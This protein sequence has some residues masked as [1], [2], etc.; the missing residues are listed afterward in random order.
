MA[1]VMSF[2][3]AA[4][5]PATGRDEQAIEALVSAG[6]VADEG[7]AVDFDDV[8]HAALQSGRV[9]IKHLVRVVRRDLRREAHVQAPP[10]LPGLVPWLGFAGPHVRV[11]EHERRGEVVPARVAQEVAEVQRVPGAVTQHALERRARPSERLDRFAAEGLHDD[12]VGGAPQPVAASG[13]DGQVGKFP[14]HG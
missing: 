4:E 6:V 14:S 13:F 11:A 5:N 9:E 1:A 8:V 7:A 10:L 3:V 2:R 12:A